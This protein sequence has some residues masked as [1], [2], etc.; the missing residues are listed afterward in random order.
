MSKRDEVPLFLTIPL[1]LREQIYK[2]VLSK[3][4]HGFAFLRTCREIYTEAHK[5]LF[6]R[7]LHFRSQAT[8]Y[9]WLEYIP[10]QHL[11]Q[12]AEIR[13]ELQDVDL[14]PLLAPASSSE[15]TTTPRL[16][17]WELYEKDLERLESSL[18][19]L[20]NL[21]TLT[22]G[23]LPERQTFLYREYL[24]K[25][26]KL[27][28]SVWPGLQ[29]LT[30]EGNF[31]HQSLS[32]LSSLPKLQSLSFDG[33]SSS[34]ATEMA[35]ILAGLHRLENLSLVSQHGLLTPTTCIH[36]DFTSQLQ[37][38]TGNVL[39][40]MNQLASLSVRERIHSA[41]SPA[42]FFTPEMLASLHCHSTLNSLTICMSQAPNPETLEAFEAFLKLA[43]I[44]HLELDWPS[45]ELQV[46]NDYEMFPPSLKYLW[47][48]VSSMATTFEILYTVFES[49]EAGDMLDLR[50]IILLRSAWANQTTEAEVDFS[51]DN[52]A[53]DNTTMHENEQDGNVVM[54]G[55]EW[56]HVSRLL[57]Q[58]LSLSRSMHRYDATN[59]LG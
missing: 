11:H 36:S 13:I 37:S 43:P 3:P 15:P 39:R 40:T 6:H 33:F 18:R 7:P 47:V 58:L 44:K 17:A 4:S 45:L 59:N 38:F 14:G 53:E 56:N 9:E 16:L 28:S 42:L 27:L 5:Y 2:E 48:R 31:H 41:A 8:F 34:S 35:G 21:K 24:S 54:G 10:S 55:E 29:G 46:L 12:V 32:F 1:E 25:F 49:R 50:K 51:I 19:S 57:L 23:A 20:P 26:I 30:L 52:N 22:I